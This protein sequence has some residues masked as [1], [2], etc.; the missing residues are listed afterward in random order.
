MRRRNSIASQSTRASLARTE[1][2]LVECPYL[3]RVPAEALRNAHDPI[4]LASPERR[5]HV[6][7][8]GLDGCKCI[9]A[10]KLVERLADGWTRTTAQKAFDARGLL[11]T[12][13]T[14]AASQ[15][16]HA[17]STVKPLAACGPDRAADVA[18]EFES[19]RV[20]AEGGKR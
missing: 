11:S 19:G 6:H 2:L 14:V 7:K 18:E 4:D 10:S 16:A 13:E 20:A 9:E 12:A 17:L 8:D 3:K 1:A 15:E 5:V